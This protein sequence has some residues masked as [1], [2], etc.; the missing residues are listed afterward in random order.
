M[1]AN[2][3]WRMCLVVWDLD[4]D[5]MRVRN[6]AVLK[7][8]T[9]IAYSQKYADGACKPDWRTGNRRPYHIF[10]EL[11]ALGFHSGEEEVMADFQFYR[12]IGWIKDHNHWLDSERR[13]ADRV[14]EL[15]S[16]N[17]QLRMRL[18]RFETLTKAQQEVEIPG[19]MLP[20]LI[21]L[22]H[23]DRHGNSE[24]SNKVTAWL[25]AQRSTMDTVKEKD[26]T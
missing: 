19:A 5:S 9:N 2:I 10:R 16:E 11:R 17:R 22:C 3:T 1:R 13:K 18:A 8:P 15:E 6:V 20:R 4:R 12:V 25:L 7:Y 24:S 14:A 21:R 23:P 26:F